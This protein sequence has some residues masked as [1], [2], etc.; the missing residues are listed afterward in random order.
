MVHHLEDSFKS[1]L[2]SI[3]LLFELELSVS[4]AID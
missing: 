4:N 3:N 2:V 1:F